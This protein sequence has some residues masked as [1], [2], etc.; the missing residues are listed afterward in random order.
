MQEGAFYYL[1]IAARI[2]FRKLY[3]EDKYA[4]FYYLLIAAG[5]DL[6]RLR[7]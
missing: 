4:T 6:Y 7:G 5:V 3:A 1:L 2:S